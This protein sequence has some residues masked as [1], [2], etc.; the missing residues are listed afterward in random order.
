MKL[1]QL[2]HRNSGQQ[3]GEVW[4]QRGHL[5]PLLPQSRR[6]ALGWRSSDWCCFT[7]TL[8]GLSQLHFT[9]RL[10]LHLQFSLGI[11][12]KK[13]NYLIWCEQNALN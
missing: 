13:K 10:F 1:L 8:L 7:H 11:P 3:Q 5:C 2:Q 4:K 6:G 9:Q 12:L